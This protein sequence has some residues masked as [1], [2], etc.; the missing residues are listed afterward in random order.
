MIALC[1]GGYCCT[2]CHGC[3]DGCGLAM[4]CRVGAAIAHGLLK[5]PQLFSQTQP[6]VAVLSRPAGYHVA[7]HRRLA[8][9]SA[10]GR[11]GVAS[12]GLGRGGAGLAASDLRGSGA[13]GAGGSGAATRRCRS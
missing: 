7:Q 9:E 13:G 2:C 1:T 6:E 12:R 4:P 5:P 11:P 3:A 8:A 10:T